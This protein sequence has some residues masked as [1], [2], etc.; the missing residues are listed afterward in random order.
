M[1]APGNYRRIAVALA[2]SFCCAS[3]S[4]AR[5]QRAEDEIR[6]VFEGYRLAVLSR[7]G[8]AALPAMSLATLQYY[9]SMQRPT[10]DVWNPLLTPQQCGHAG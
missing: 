4:F 5:G 7:D 1:I 3:P 2:L 10:D 9:R 6:A 8:Q